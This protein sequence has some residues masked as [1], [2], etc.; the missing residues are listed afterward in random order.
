MSLLWGESN[1]LNFVSN[2]P[3]RGSSKYLVKYYFVSTRVYQTILIFEILDRVK[4]TAFH[5]LSE[6]HAFKSRLKIQK[7]CVREKFL[8]DVMGWGIKHVLILWRILSNIVDV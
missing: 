5:I 7:G 4:Q 1:Y 2:F 8:S 6:P 3:D